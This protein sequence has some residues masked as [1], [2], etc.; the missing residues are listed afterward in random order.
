[1]IITYYISPIKKLLVFLIYTSLF[2]SVLVFLINDKSLWYEYGTF[3]AKIAVFLYLFTL[4]PG[5]LQRLNLATKVKGLYILL[6]TLRRS[7]G[8]LTFVLIWYHFLFLRGI[9]SILSGQIYKPST[10]FE[11]F[12][13]IAFQLLFLMFITSNGISVKKLGKWWGRIHSLTYVIIWFIMIHVSFVNMSLAV[14][15]GIFAILELYSILYKKLK[16]K[17]E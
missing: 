13:F 17:Y 7:I 9:A 2:M 10:L 3:C 12:G 11:V 6:N 14:L 4:I 5:I 1:M 16:T 15:L 8:I